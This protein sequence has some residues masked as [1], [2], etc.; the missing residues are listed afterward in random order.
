MIY[1]DMHLIAVYVYRSKGVL[2]AAVN[3]A[4]LHPMGLSVNHEKI[5][6]TCK[7]KGH[8][9]MPD[10]TITVV[11]WTELSSFSTII[12]FFPVEH[13]VASFQPSNITLNMNSYGS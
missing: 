4:T 9:N 1:Q 2:E 12:K 5:I 7:S 13:T 11:L 3:V 10:P 6:L 8:I